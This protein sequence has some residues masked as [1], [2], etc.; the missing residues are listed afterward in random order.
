M[1]LFGNFHRRNLISPT[2]LCLNAPEIA[3]QTLLDQVAECAPSLH[4]VQRVANPPV[5]ADV[6]ED[7]SLRVLVLETVPDTAEPAIR[8]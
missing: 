7:K 6:N 1:L 4:F 2:M 5:F 8:G 3:T